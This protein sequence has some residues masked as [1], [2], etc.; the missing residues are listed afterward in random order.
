MLSLRGRCDAQLKVRGVR[1]ETGEV[2]AAL[3]QL[4]DVEDAAVCGWLR[5]ASETC[6]E[7]GGGGELVLLALVVLQRGMMRDAG[8]DGPGSSD[9]YR[10]DRPF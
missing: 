3:R 9:N 2:E 5:P 8:G 6:R 4:P 7:V 10:A 1:V